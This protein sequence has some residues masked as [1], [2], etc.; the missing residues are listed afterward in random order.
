VKKLTAI[1]LSALF[2]FNTLGFT[3]YNHYCPFK[4]SSVSFFAER[5]CCCDNKMPDGCCE[6]KTQQIKIKD[7]YSVTKTFDVK[8]AGFVIA[9][10]HPFVSE[11]A[12]SPKTIQA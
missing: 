9:G 2:L 3:L 1:L 10:F 8:T 4:G 7:S 11:C 6:N 5:S 12:L